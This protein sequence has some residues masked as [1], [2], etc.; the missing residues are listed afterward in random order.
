M[1][2]C[3]EIS[4][5]SCWSY[6]KKDRA[7]GHWTMVHWTIFRIPGWKLGEPNP[8]EGMRARCSEEC[9]KLLERTLNRGLRFIPT[10]TL[11]P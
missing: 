7:V 10:C 2:T 8:E 3:A 4:E 5:E 11:E 6:T 1:A 9:Y